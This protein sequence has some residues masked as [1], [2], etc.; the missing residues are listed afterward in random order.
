M[1][2]KNRQITTNSPKAWFLASRP[3]TLTGAATPVLIGLGM[4]FHDTGKLML[5]PTLL[6]ILFAFVMQIDANFVNDYFDFK[7][8]TDDATR[9]GP[10]RA[11]SE[12]WI[13]LKGMKYGIVF[14]T[15]S[16]CIIGLPLAFYGG[17]PMVIVGLAC[18]AFCI[19]YTTS[20]SYKGLGDILVLIFFG[21]VPVMFTYYV[22]CGTFTIPTLLL[23]LACGMV[24]DTLLIVNNFRDRETDKMAGKRTLI[25][26]VGERWGHRLYF[27]CGLTG[28][29][30]EIAGLALM[31]S[32]TIAYIFPLLYVILMQRT[33]VKM[34]RIWKGKQLNSILGE[35]AR[36]IF[37]FGILC[38]CSIILS[39][40]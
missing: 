7:K 5:L 8:G 1:D 19:L 24:I 18:V 12:G 29:I 14:T 39:T 16:A 38:V 26:I 36:N 37:L 3:K 25:V 27:I 30:L 9:L 31:E 40:I 21:I 20:L 11:C 28:V 33:F 17:W 13:T 10:K 34:K 22:Q 35:T 6:C 2:I 32:N 23:S 4:V 15:L